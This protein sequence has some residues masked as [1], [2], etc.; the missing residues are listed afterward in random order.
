MKDNK[1]IVEIGAGNGN[2]L[3]LLHSK[4]LGSCVIDVDLP[5]TLSVAFVFLADMFPEA[6]F[7]LPNE[8]EGANFS[9]FDFVF[10]TP[11]QINKIQNDSVDLFINTDSF[12]EMTHEQIEEY[13]Y[14]IQVGGKEGG[15]FFTRNRVEKFPWGS[16]S[17]DDRENLGPP[18]NRF[19]DYPWS[20]SNK[21]LAFESCK[22]RELV[23]TKSSMI[24]LEKI[25]KV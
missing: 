8:V 15:Y 5:E 17:F 21:I 1:R 11:G 20:K 7:L 6:R 13:F 14:F 2:L 12:Q 18:P 19:W 9:D 22:L 24:R 23:G 3:A 4:V 16:A 10:L 25:I